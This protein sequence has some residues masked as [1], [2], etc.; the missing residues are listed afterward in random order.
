AM[1]SARRVITAM[2]RE[3]S[4]LLA[5]RA[6]AEEA[7]TQFLVVLVGAG[8]LVAAF[9]ALLAND[10]LRRGAVAQANTARLLDQ[11]NAALRDQAAERERLLAEVA[12]ANQAKMQFLARM[13]HELRT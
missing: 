1:D 7:Y 9:L 6:A 10:M 13:S 12:A 2:Q 4:R 8:S 3:E 11:R 5:S